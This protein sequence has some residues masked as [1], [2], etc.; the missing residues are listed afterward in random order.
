M[1]Y[2]KGELSQIDVQDVQLVHIIFFLYCFF[3]LRETARDTFD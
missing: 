3:F 1:G 2:Q